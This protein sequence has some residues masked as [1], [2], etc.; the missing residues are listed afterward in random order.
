MLT[1]L[2]GM[3]IKFLKSFSVSSA[4]K[5]L[6]ACCAI[7]LNTKILF[8]TQCSTWNVLAELEW[9]EFQ[10]AWLLVQ[11]QWWTLD[12]LQS[13][14]PVAVRTRIRHLNL[15]L[16]FYMVIWQLLLRVH[17][18]NL[19]VLLPI[20]Y[21]SPQAPLKPPLPIPHMEVLQPSLRPQSPSLI[22]TFGSPS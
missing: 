15:Y 16:V 22:W 6:Y 17:F 3:Q 21:L 10:A 14:S 9:E 11:C 18:Y 2:Q 4:S 12:S 19:E 1:S 5:L 20:P 8:C 13:P 7:L